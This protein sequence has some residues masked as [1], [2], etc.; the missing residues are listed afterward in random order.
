MPAPALTCVFYGRDLEEV[1]AFSRL[2]ISAPAKNLSLVCKYP[3]ESEESE[4]EEEEEGL[5]LRSKGKEFN[6]RL[7]RH[8][9][10]AVSSR[11]CPWRV[12]T[13]LGARS[14]LLSQAKNAQG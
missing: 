3:H 2:A 9:L 4:E 5:Y 8:V 12:P 11:S 7:E 6:R 13:C 14:S 1:V 10:L